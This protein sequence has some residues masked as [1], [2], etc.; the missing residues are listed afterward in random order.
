MKVG[1]RAYTELSIQIATLD[2][3]LDAILKLLN[4]P[5]VEDDYSSEV[6]PD[7]GPAGNGGSFKWS[8]VDTI[9]FCAGSAGGSGGGGGNT[10]IFPGESYKD[11]RKRMGEYNEAQSD[12]ENF[13]DRYK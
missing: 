10:P 13:E 3:K 8:G 2:M 5:E 7:Y 4:K 9:T 6:M 11:Y 1:E 12:N